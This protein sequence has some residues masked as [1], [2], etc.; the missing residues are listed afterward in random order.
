MVVKRA[1]SLAD[2]RTARFVLGSLIV[3]GAV[4]RFLIA[5]QD[6]FAN[7]LATYWIVS[8]RSFSR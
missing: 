2:D 5:R 7:E 1:V 6:L 4:I 8:T 3:V